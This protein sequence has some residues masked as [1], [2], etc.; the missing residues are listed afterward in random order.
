M[1]VGGGPTGPLSPGVYQ[2]VKGDLVHT[3]LH[4]L[5]SVLNNCG[6]NQC[7]YPLLT[8][9]SQLLHTANRHAPLN[10]TTMT[11]TKPQCEDTITG[12]MAL[13]SLCVCLCAPHLSQSSWAPSISR[14]SL[15]LAGLPATDKGPPRLGLFGKCEQLMRIKRPRTEGWSAAFYLQSPG[16][17]KYTRKIKGVRRAN[18]S[19]SLTFA[20][21]HL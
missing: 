21:I 8:D 16:G 3:Y 11:H 18:S 12:K 19:S 2:Q 6:R 13:L 10:G 7:V 5:L 15:Q 17:R 4:T 9:C 1:K 20:V 14:L